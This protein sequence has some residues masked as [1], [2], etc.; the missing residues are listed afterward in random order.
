M[1]I[2]VVDGQAGLPTPASGDVQA[3][4]ATPTVSWSAVG[5]RSAIHDE[6]QRLIGEYPTIPAGSVLRCFARALR[7]ARLHGF[8]PGETVPTAA[9]TAR[10]ALSKRIGGSPGA[11]EQPRGSGSTAG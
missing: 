11:S 5:L 4:T 2:P 8:P 3:E 10:L 6:A 9:K 1:S 7:L